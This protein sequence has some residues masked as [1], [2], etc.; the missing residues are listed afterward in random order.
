MDLLV[1]ADLC[2]MLPIDLALTKHNNRT[3]QTT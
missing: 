1:A 3:K 2:V